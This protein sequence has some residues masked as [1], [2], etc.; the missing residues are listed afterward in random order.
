[1][2]VHFLLIMHF[3]IFC[4]W[5]KKVPCFFFFLV[6]ENAGLVGR[7]KIG[8]FFFQELAWSMALIKNY[9]Q[10]A[11]CVKM[12]ASISFIEWFFNSLLLFRMIF[13][14]HKKDL[15]RV[16]KLQACKTERRVQG[17]AAGCENCS[18]KPPAAAITSS[19]TLQG[20]KEFYVHIYLDIK[21]FTYA[22]TPPQLFILSLSLKIRCK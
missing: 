10:Q 4:S 13:V 7:A 19:Q 14:L 15:H 9:M 2:L 11:V 3:Y 18:K 20:N 21:K 8:D 12:L 22:R 1:M 6:T 17:R 16:L 5:S